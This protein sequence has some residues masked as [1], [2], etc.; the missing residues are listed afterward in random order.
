MDIWLCSVS[1]PHFDI[2]DVLLWCLQCRAIKFNSVA[3][4]DQ[5]N[6]GGDDNIPNARLH[7]FSVLTCHSMFFF[8]L[9]NPLTVCLLCRST[10][11]NGN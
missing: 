7:I 2:S 5:P 6:C 3:N 11:D 10:V 1:T 9:L 8:V 4:M